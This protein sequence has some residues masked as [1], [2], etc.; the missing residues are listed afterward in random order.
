ME[1]SYYY[2]HAIT[3]FQITPASFIHYMKKKLEEK[4]FDLNRIDTDNGVFIYVVSQ[5]NEKNIFNEAQYRKIQKFT[6]KNNE[7]SPD[8][9]LHHKIIYYE[10]RKIVSFKNKDQFL[11]EMNGDSIYNLNLY[12]K[13]EKSDDDLNRYNY[14]L[15]LFTESEIQSL[16]FKIIDEIEVDIDYFMSL[17]KE[18]KINYD[19]DLL[20]IK[21]SETHS[22]FEIYK[23]LNFIEIIPLH[24]SNYREKI[25]FNSIFS[26]RCCFNQI[27]NYYGDKVAI[28]YAWMST[29]Q[30]NL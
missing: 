9:V 23:F 17:I 24:Y 19:E 12:S 10:G 30:S 18:E 14:G 16:E 4:D 21:L 28:Y 20:R 15:G 25:S 3:V 6:T 1:K 26:A 2:R 5:K 27:R 11:P 29:Y 8:N 13:K 7:L 22:L